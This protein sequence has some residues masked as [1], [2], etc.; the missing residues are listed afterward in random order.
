MLSLVGA[1][2]CDSAGSFEYRNEYRN[3]CTGSN[4]PLLHPGLCYV[5]GGLVKT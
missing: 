1:A 3:G 4:G 2:T 5:A